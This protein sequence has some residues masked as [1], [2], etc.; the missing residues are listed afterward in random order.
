MEFD[1]GDQG[2]VDTDNPADCTTDIDGDAICDLHDTCLLDGPLF[3]SFRDL[4]SN[5]IITITNVEIN[6]GTN[7]EVGIARGST[8]S[9]SYD[10]YYNSSSHCCE[11]T[12]YVSLG[13]YQSTAPEH[14]QPAFTGCVS[15]G[16]HET[17]LVAPMEPG[18]Y[19]IGFRMHWAGTCPTDWHSPP[20]TQTFA[21]ICVE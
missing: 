17:T 20:K 4:T 8:F 10:W 18:T 2:L 12:T 16:R 19:Y 7:A 1:F 14:C 3:T 15:E 21:A 9:I 5:Q 13:Y 6:G 11:C